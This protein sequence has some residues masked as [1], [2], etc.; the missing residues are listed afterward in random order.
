[1]III[2]GKGLLPVT[3]DAILWVAE[4]TIIKNVGSFFEMDDLVSLSDGTTVSGRI[5]IRPLL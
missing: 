5:A 1:M 4:A 2:P 3:S